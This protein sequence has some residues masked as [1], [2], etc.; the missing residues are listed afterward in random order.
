[1]SAKKE[2]AKKLGIFTT[3]VIAALS[4][5]GITINPAIVTV[6]DAVQ[7]AIVD[8]GELDEQAED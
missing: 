5:F 2:K 6:I 3:L 7:D 4:A 1:M 8:I